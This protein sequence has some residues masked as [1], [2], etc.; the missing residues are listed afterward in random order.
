MAANAS[1]AASS[2][3]GEVAPR[4]PQIDKR[5]LNAATS[6]DST[7]MQALASQNPG[8]LLGTTL[9]G[10]TCLHI[11]STYGHQGFC[12]DVVALENLLLTVENLDGETPLLAAVASGRARVASIL[13][14]CYQARQLSA[15]IL[16]QDKEGCN[17]LHH[18]IH[19]G[20]RE[21]A[22]ELI[23]AEPA[24]SKHVNKHG[25]ST[26]F[27]AALR[28]FTHVFEKLLNIP[29][30]SHAGRHSEN[31]LHAVV[32][33]GDEDG[34]RKIMGKRPELARAADDLQ[35]STPATVAVLYN[36]TKVL[37]VL[38]EHD[39]SLGYVIT[40]KG[41][42]L[43]V[44]AASRGHVHVA[45]ELLRHCP[46]ASYQR[47]SDNYTWLH[48]AVRFDHAEFVEFIMR[49][50]QLSKLVN[51]RDHIGKT[52]LHL[53]VQKCN[54]R[55]VASLLSHECIDATVLDNSNTAATWKLTT[56]TQNAKT[57]NWASDSIYIS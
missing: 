3:G 11:A 33:N 10:N 52:A 14:R 16:W 47:A 13:L 28:N 35:G 41:N 56:F 48:E 42:P 53:A 37:R 1:T 38:L 36:K 51:M 8:I 23:E 40:R 24:L 27:I 15:A 32:R 26:M 45:G 50:P 5:L 22:L 29:E 9:T 25:E 57:L 17:A 19:S 2:S 34:A 54:P 31:A 7:S 49:R 12:M 18:A 4:P 39:C 30:S 55:I 6:G 21:L 46:D 44:C 20:H 43:L